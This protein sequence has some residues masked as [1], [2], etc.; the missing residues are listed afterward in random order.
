MLSVFVVETLDIKSQLEYI[1]FV[2]I[3]GDV[4][5]Y[6][7]LSYVG[8]DVYMLCVCVSSARA[9]T[10]RVDCKYSK[11]LAYTHHSALTHVHTCITYIHTC[12]HTYI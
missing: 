10:E 3:V 6:R 11:T 12:L 8:I 2:V 7:W 9:H 4:R 1:K 5:E